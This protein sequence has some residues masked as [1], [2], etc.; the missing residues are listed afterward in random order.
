VIE[1]IIKLMI[2]SA[3]TISE[4]RLSREAAAAPVQKQQQQQ[5]GADEQLQRMIWHPR[6]ISAAKMG[7]S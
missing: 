5:N 3:D 4:E 2:R 6:G 1:E 7:S